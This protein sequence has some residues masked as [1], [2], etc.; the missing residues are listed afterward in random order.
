[1]WRM[2]GVPYAKN[3]FERLVFRFVCVILCCIDMFDL[4]WTGF[5]TG[6]A[7]SFSDTLDLHL[8]HVFLLK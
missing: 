3:L 8:K 4:F 7:I 2:A 1:M 5:A 6:L